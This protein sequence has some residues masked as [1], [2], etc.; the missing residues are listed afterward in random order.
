MTPSLVRLAELWLC[1]RWGRIKDQEVR[2]GTVIA[3]RDR[4]KVFLAVPLGNDSLGV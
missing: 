1:P 3:Q 2:W 4:K